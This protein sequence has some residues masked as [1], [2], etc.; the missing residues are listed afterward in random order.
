MAEL[1]AGLK[2][3]T[4]MSIVVTRANGCVI[5]LGEITNSQWGFFR[6]LKEKRRIK[7]LLGKENVEIGK[8]IK[9]AQKLSKKK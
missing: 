5:D 2:P 6:R 7:K 9:H 4:S 8:K 3:Q 1:S